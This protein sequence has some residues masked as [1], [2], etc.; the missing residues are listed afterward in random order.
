MKEKILKLRR[1]GKTY[2][3]ITKILNCA[4]ST[5][6]YHCKNEGLSQPT[7]KTEI[8]SLDEAKIKDLYISGVSKKSLSEM[9][10]VSQY[11]ISKSTK[12][13]KRYS[14]FDD[15]ISRKERQVVYVTERRRKLKEMAVTYKGGKCEKCGYNECIAAL[16]FHHL[17]PLE[18]DF[19]IGNKGYTRS[20]ENIKKEI[21]KC[22]LVCAN[23][24]REIHSNE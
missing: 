14:K 2:N 23:C 9:Y 7:E 6:S 18:K 16:D 8:T 22:I 13:L 1:D 15:T 12:G 4:K 21:D 5:V 3:E 19:S 24:H 11:E 17:N 10:N 20:W